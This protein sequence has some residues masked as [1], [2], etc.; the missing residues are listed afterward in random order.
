M[1][2]RNISRE[3]SYSVCPNIVALKTLSKYVE[4]I[5]G[6]SVL[7]HWNNSLITNSKK[8]KR[9]IGIKD[10]LSLFLLLCVAPFP[11]AGGRGEQQIN[12]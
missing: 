5:L 11:G 6:N 2:I 3:R 7:E 9:D 12:I 1:Y 10:F 8:K 4:T